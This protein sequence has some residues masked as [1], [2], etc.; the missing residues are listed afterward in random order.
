MYLFG[1]I[2]IN[3]VRTGPRLAILLFKFLSEE[4]TKSPA[5]VNEP[6]A[7]VSRSVSELSPIVALSTTTLS[8]VSDAAVKAPEISAEVKL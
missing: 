7:T 4:V 1:F 3:F 5:S 8:T 6:L 2:E